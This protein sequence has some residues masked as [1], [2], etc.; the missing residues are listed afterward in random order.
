MPIGTL[1]IVPLVG[2]L[3]PLVG[4]RRL[5]AAGMLGAAVTS[6]LFLGIDLGT[7][8]WW[9]SGIMFL[10]G[11]AFGLCIIPVQAATYATVKPRDMG[12]ATSLFSTGRQVGT[13]LSI[14]VLITVLATRTQTHVAAALRT[15]SSAAAAAQHGA[16]LGF[17]DAFAASALIALAGVAFALLIRDEEAAATMRRAAPVPQEA[18]AVAEPDV[19]AVQAA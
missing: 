1:V 19:E 3:Y 2:R 12:R 18:A 4:P 8:L 15:A 9:I 14:G 11:L 6:L 5:I 10:R 7:N 17:H 13:S 16:L